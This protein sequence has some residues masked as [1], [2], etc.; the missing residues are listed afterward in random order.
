MDSVKTIMGDGVSYTDNQ[1]VAQFMTMLK[2]TVCLSTG[3]TICLIN[4]DGVVEGEAAGAKAWKENVTMR[5]RLESHLAP[6]NSRIGSR[7]LIVKDRVGGQ[8]RSFGYKFAA[9]AAFELMDGAELVSR[10]DEHI[11]WILWEAYLT[12]KQFLRKA[13]IL[14]E[15][16]K[17]GIADSTVSNTLSQCDTADLIR[18]EG[19]RGGR[20]IPVDPERHRSHCCL[21]Q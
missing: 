14:E 2:S 16:R 19:L 13:S 1:V 6:D 8:N 5:T 7:A 10:C 17:V 11:A 15:T 3:A 4:H 12:G 18:P 20:C 9:N 21:S